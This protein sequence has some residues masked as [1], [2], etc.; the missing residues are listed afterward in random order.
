MIT[1]Q[2]GRSHQILSTISGWVTVDKYDNQFNR[3]LRK[4][5]RQKKTAKYRQKI[6]ERIDI[7]NDA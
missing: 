6:Q 2:A 7:K 1:K 4:N 3:R 5:F